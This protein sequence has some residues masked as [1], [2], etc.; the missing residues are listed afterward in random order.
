MSICISCA[1][2][3]LTLVRL[4]LACLERVRKRNRPVPPPNLVTSSI[5]PPH[6]LCTS[7][8]FLQPGLRF[9]FLPS[10]RKL[11][12]L[13]NIVSK[14]L[15]VALALHPVAC[16][17]AFLSFIVT[18]FA[19]F[20]R[21]RH[22]QTHGTERDGRSR[23]SSIMTFAIILPAALLTT[24]V[25]IV[26]VVLVAIARH[27]LRD[28]VDGSRSVQLTWDSGVSPHTIML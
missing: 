4:S 25:F 14:T 3:F 1:L 9:T 5:P 12:D 15:T 6:V 17:L 16:V 10:E 22:F 21:R 20:R 7:D 27:K 13:T 11:D 18:L 26:D 8:L 19:L 24:V 23:F 2:V 28:A